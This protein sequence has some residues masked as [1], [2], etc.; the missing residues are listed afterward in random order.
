MSCGGVVQQR[1]QVC[2][3]STGQQNFA[4]VG[5]PVG[6]STQVE[7][8]H[9]KSVHRNQRYDCGDNLQDKPNFYLCFE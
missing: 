1:R 7:H 6:K 4:V 5:G 8:V 3:V 9:P 2:N